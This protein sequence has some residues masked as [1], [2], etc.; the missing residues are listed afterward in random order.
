MR[1]EQLEYAVARYGTPLYLFDMDRLENEVGRIRKILGKHAGLCYAMKANPFLTARMAELT[2]RI[3]VCSMG[4]FRICRELSIPPEKLL[5][6]G[7]VKKQE[8]LFEILNCCGGRCA[9]T[10]ESVRQFHYLAEWSDAHDEALRIYLRLGG[11]S[12]FGMDEDTFYSI[13][14]L[15]NMSPRLRPEGLHYFT[16][17]QKRSLDRLK[18]EIAYLDRFLLNLKEKTGCDIRCLEYGPGISVPYFREKTAETFC[19][20]GLESLAEM[21]SGMEW[22]GDVTVELGRAFAAMCGYYLTGICDVKTSGDTN[23]CMVDGGSHQLNYDGQIRGMYEPYIRMIPEALPGQERTWTVCGSLC[24]VNDILCRDIRLGGV[25]T[26]RT[27]VFER[28]GAYSAMEG[29][30]LFLSHALPQVV[31]YSSADGWNMLRGRKE[32]WTVN[33]AESAKAPDGNAA[34]RHVRRPSDCL[35]AVH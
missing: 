10:V 17:T 14:G 29:M 25:R 24:S 7:V 1:K 27:L 26:G 33:M 8:D 21:L 16:G 31:S 22:N 30:A 23:Y 11:D 15:V 20:S 18:K 4:E 9:Y 19:D 34:D 2:D 32:T 13:I 35:A 6:S 28:A 3:E 5:I 12:Q